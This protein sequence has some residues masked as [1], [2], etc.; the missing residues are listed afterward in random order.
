M[1]TADLDIWRLAKL[2]IDQDGARALL[3]AVQRA[4]ELLASGD[5]EGQAVWKRI[6]KAVG[7][8]MRTKSRDDDAMN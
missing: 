4:D 8:L 3:V 6:L 1:P 7:A 5:M 2:L